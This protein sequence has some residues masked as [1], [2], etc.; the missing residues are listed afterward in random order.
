MAAGVTTIG[1][2]EEERP[3]AG[4]GQAPAQ[5]LPGRSEIPSSNKKPSARPARDSKARPAA[6]EGQGPPGQEIELR[7]QQPEKP[8]RGVRWRC[9]TGCGACCKLD[10]GPEFL[11]P[12]KDKA[13]GADHLQ[14]Y[15]SMIG[16]DG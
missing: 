10:K 2:E 7:N 1:W 4:R 14:L 12:D 13:D 5:P 11:T 3:A 6:E 8:K 15:K 9:S 16:P